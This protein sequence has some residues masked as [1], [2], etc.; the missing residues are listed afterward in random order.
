[1]RRSGLIPFYEIFQRKGLANRESG[2]YN[3]SVNDQNPA[4]GLPG[5]Y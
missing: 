1:M 3:E 2:L 5:D 4:E